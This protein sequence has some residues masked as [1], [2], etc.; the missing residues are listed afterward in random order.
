[1][2]STQRNGCHAWFSAVILGAFVAVGCEDNDAEGGDTD[3]GSELD[4]A[5]KDGPSEG[6]QGLE[7]DASDVGQTCGNTDDACEACAVE[8]CESLATECCNTAGCWAIVEC[9]QESGCVGAACLT[10]CG[11]EVSTAGLEVTMGIGASFG[12][13]ITMLCAAECGY[14]DAGS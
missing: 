3:P 2:G 8:N 9:V 6:N 14:A 13:C 7:G 10:P 12:A 5:A 11:E 1:M 4:A